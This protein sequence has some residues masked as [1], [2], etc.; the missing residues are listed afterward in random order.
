MAEIMDGRGLEGKVNISLGV[1]PLCCQGSDNKS[2]HNGLTPA[3]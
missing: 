2:N 1:R 3:P